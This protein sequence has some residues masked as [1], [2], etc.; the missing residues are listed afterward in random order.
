MGKKIDF[1]RANRR[2]GEVFLQMGKYKEALKHEN[3]YLST[4]KTE[5]DL[6]EMQRAYATIGRCY[7]LQAEDESLS[8]SS[9][10]PSDL[11]SAE[12]AFLKSLMICK[13]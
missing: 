10:A 3:I 8:G 9:D 1:A 13:E 11:K 5:N 4:A 12:K 2:I 6:V 7:L